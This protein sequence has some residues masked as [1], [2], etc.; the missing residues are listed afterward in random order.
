MLL[1]LL[2]GMMIM[3]IIMV[4]L[5]IIIF[6]SLVPLYIY[7]FFLINKLQ[8]FTVKN[9]FHD[10]YLLDHKPLYLLDHKSLS[11]TL[12]LIYFYF[13]GHLSHC[14][15]FVPRNWPPR[16]NVNNLNSQIG[17]NQWKF[18]TSLMIGHNH[19]G[20][21]M[22]L[23]RTNERASSSKPRPLPFIQEERR[24]LFPLIDDVYILTV[25]YH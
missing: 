7:I 20:G 18:A 14:R 4:I 25:H 5:S 22:P 9:R 17:V 12:F 3:M 16:L 15:S 10:K 19:V 6:S 11:I 1:L 8:T 21:V 13:K 24:E 23:L 2:I